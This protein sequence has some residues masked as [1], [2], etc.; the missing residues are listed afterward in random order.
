MQCSGLH[1][2]APR[3][4]VFSDEVLKLACGSSLVE[5]IQV[6]ESLQVRTVNSLGGFFAI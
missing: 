2:V 6:H 3:C 5:R 4:D 1:V